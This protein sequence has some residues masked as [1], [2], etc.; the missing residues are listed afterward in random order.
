MTGWQGRE[1]RLKTPLYPKGTPWQTAIQNG[2]KSVMTLVLLC[3]KVGSTFCDFLTL[4][5][6]E[7]ALR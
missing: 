5:G 1:I 3:H 4:C 2:D 7:Y 6:M